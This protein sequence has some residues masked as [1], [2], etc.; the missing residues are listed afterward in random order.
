MTGDLSTTRRARLRLQRDVLF[1]ECVAVTSLLMYQTAVRFQIRFVYISLFQGNL[2][3]LSLFY[4]EDGG[5]RLLRNFC[6]YLPNYMPS[7][8]RRL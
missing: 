6:T 8:L 5:N 1:V 4:P 3:P 7:H 2:L